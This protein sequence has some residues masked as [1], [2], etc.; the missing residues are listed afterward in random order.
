M[1]RERNERI[2]RASEVGQYLYCP[3]AW[4]LGAVEGHTSTNRRALARGDT[5]HR[6]HGL[7]VRASVAAARAAYL[8]LML[9]LLAG[10]VALWQVVR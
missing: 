7:Q 10:V 3:R 5:A 8:L 1:G 9:A 4:W 6:Q 2:I